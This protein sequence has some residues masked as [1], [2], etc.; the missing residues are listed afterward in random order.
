M[1]G[2]IV[3]LGLFFGAAL[4]PQD[5]HSQQRSSVLLNNDILVMKA[6]GISFLGSGMNEDDAKT[7]AINDAKRNALEQAGTYL[8]ANSTVLN[9]QL[10]NDEVITFSAGLVKVKV[11]KEARTVINN[12]FAFQVNIEATIDIKLLDER[13]KEL[14]SDSSLK[15]QLEA[16]GEKIKQLETKIADLQTS[17][18][19]ASKQTVKNV[20]NELSAVDW[21]NKGWNTNDKNI[22]IDCF[23][24][25]IEL[26]PQYVAAYH[27]RGIA[28]GNL[29]NHNAALQDFN[30]AI[31]LDPQ[32]AAAY[33]NRGIA[34]GNLGNR[35]A[36]LQDFNKAIELDPKYARGYYSRGIAYGNLGK[37][38]A[39]LQDF[40]RAIELDPKY[41]VAYGNRGLAYGHL[42]KHDAAIRDFT[43][44]IELDPKDAIAYRNRGLAYKN[45]GNDEAAIRDYNKAIELDPTYA[46]AYRNRGDAYKTL[47]KKR[48]AADDYNSYLRIT[49]NKAGNTEM[50]RQLIKD[51]GY[52]PQY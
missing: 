15:E 21:Y 14:R 30:R 52:L 23:T 33:R 50:V 19:T 9:Y 22:Q 5:V 27:S 29:G 3:L 35:D 47:N 26:N 42:G 41:A 34:Y 24:N 44:A 4:I 32:Y 13:I 7:F 37:H 16:Q 17:N 12:I 18:S 48:E 25:A 10:V 49:G 1:R 36:A 45:S 6:E 11:L 43:K 46:A 31:E 39:A 40:N 38:G 8:E 28:N 51:L 20:L 2:R